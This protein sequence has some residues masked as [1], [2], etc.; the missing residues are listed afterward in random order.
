MQTK[1][2]SEL[3]IS[4]EILK[5]IVEMG[6][7]IATPIQSQAIP[8]LLEGKD[9]IGQAM[10]GTGKTVAFAIPAIEAVDP[11]INKPQI[12]ILCPTREL[13]T[14]VALEIGKLSKFKENIH[15]LPIYGGQPIDRQIRALKRG[16]Q[17][18]VG[19]PG[20]ILDHLERK[21]I[22]FNSIKTIILDEADE[23]LNM[24][25]VTDIETIL[26]SVP[27]ERQ[28]VLFSATMSKTILNLTKKYQRDPQL[29][30]ITHEK[31]SIPKIEQ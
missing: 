21:T 20:R 8:L 23:M 4:R 24:G 6:F 9:I 19:T 28:T 3:N 29:V 10:T 14:Q 27:K 15:E 22:S 25:F 13:A 7:E 26:K 31:F 2:F 1:K 16:P 30:K 11:N 12:L 18:I 5:A 17:I